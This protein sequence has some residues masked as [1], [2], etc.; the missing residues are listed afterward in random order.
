MCKNDCIETGDDMFFDMNE[1][2]GI[3]VLGTIIGVFYLLKKGVD[4]AF[5]TDDNKKTMADTIRELRASN[6]N[7]NFQHRNCISHRL[8][9]KGKKVKPKGFGVANDTIPNGEINSNK[10]KKRNKRK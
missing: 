3:A 1:F 9:G 10:N 4:G 8:G 6:L 7:R 5:D 2:G